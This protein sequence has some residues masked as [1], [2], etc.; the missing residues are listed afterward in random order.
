MIQFHGFPAPCLILVAVA[1]NTA[2]QAILGDLALVMGPEERVG[3]V[4]AVTAATVF[5]ASGQHPEEW[6]IYKRAS[7]YWDSKPPGRTRARTSSKAFSR[8]AIVAISSACMGSVRFVSRIPS[9]FSSFSV[10]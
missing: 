5:R 4:L 1:V 8:S 9:S 6:G 10:R 7:H 3:I 2:Q